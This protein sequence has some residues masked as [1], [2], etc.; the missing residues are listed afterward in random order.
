MASIKHGRGRIPDRKKRP[1]TEGGGTERESLLRGKSKGGSPPNH[2]ACTTFCAIANKKQYPTTPYTIPLPARALGLHLHNHL[3]NIL[4]DLVSLGKH[5]N[6]RSWTNNDF[7]CDPHAMYMCSKTMFNIAAVAVVAHV[8][9]HKN[10]NGNPH[11]WPKVEQA[12]IVWTIWEI[13]PS[14][15]RVSRF[16]TS[17]Q[18]A[19]FAPDIAAKV[20]C[21][22]T[23][24]GRERL[25]QLTLRPK[26]VAASQEQQRPRRG[27]ARA[28]AGVRR[29]RES[30]LLHSPQTVQPCTG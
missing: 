20:A 11:A 1:N 22:L 7:H 25:Q 30:D 14:L 16:R 13:F 29:S 26:Q 28:G 4:N 5:H 17:S 27:R 10:T 9:R 15:A 18:E 21:T 8:A 19:T 6:T 23:G 2:N 24:V 12:W 3:N